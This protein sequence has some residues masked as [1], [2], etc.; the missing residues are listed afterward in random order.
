MLPSLPTAKSTYLDLISSL[1]SS[2][3]PSIVSLFTTISFTDLW[4]IIVIFSLKN[5][6]ILSNILIFS[7][8]PKC[9][10]LLL[11]SLTPTEIA[12]RSI[13]FTFGVSGLVI[14]F[15]APNLRLIEST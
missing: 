7:S 1:L 12:L 3:T 13:S 6:Y 14:T 10:T 4:K 5:L 2:K 15:V 9:L 11:N 8:V